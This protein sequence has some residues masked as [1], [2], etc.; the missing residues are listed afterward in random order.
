MRFLGKLAA[1][2]CTLN[3]VLGSVFAWLSLGI[4]L[5]CFGVVVLR[6]AFATSFLWM[7]D[8]YIWLSGAMFTAVGGYALLKDSHVRVDI[9]YRPAGERRKAWV[10]LIGAVLFL[11]PFMFVVVAYSWPFVSRSW[12]YFEGSANVG[13][14]PGLYVLKS[15]ILVFAISVALQGIAMICRSVLVLA[16]RGDLVPHRMRYDV[17][18]NE[19]GVA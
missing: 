12:S 3:A 5:V 16:D 17:L 7:Q 14:M 1:A 13:G 11:V 15:F 10:D 4:V 19:E 6:Y 18:A 2:I 8:L 9:F